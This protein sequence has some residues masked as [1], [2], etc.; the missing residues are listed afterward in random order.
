MTFNVLRG[1]GNVSLDIMRLGAAFVMF[2][3]Y[4]AP[5]LWNLYKTGAVPDV[6]AWAN[7]WAVILASAGL[8]IGG[9][10]FGVAK[11]NATCAQADQTK[12][13]QP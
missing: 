9:K 11:A 4:P 13:S 2:F 3:A 10:D 6:S 1:P 5:Y 7:G 8:A 12:E